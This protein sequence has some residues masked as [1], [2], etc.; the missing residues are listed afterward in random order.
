MGSASDIWRWRCAGNHLVY[1]FDAGPLRDF[2]VKESEL[3]FM[4]KI[5]T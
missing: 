1:L 5:I 2:S 4:N 3:L